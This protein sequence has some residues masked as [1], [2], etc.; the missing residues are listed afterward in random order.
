MR[1]AAL[2][3]WCALSAFAAETLPERAAALLEKRCGACHAGSMALSDL[4]LDSREALLKG[5]KRGPAIA[6]DLNAS[7]LLSVVEHRAE[8][9]MPPGGKLEASEIALLREWVLAGAAWPTKLQATKTEQWWSFQKPKRSAVPKSTWGA[10][11]IDAFLSQAHF[12]NQLNPA[13]AAD[14]ATLARRAY[15]D[16]WGIAPSAA[17]LSKFV[18]DPAPDSWPK[19]VDELLASPRYGERW[20]RHWLDLVRYGDTAGFEQDPNLLYAWRYRDYV[21]EALNADKPY[22][23]FVKEQIAGDELYP[24]EPLSAQGTGFYTVGPNRDMLY[25]VE[26]VNRE[27]SLT[28]FVDTTMSV[29]QGLT[30]GCARCHDHKFDPIPQKDYYRLRSIFMP[31]EKSRV[32][33]HYDMARGYDLSEVNRHAKL[34]EFGDQ[35]EQLYAPYKEKQKGASEEKIR[36]EMTPADLKK[37]NAIELAL[38]RMFT[39]FKAGPFSPSVRDLGREAP[40]TYLPARSG[41]PPEEVTPGFLSA[42]GGMDVPQPPR[43]AEST[44]R[45]KS[46]A[47]W[48]GSKDNPLTS[49]VMVNRIWQ[50]HFG[51]GLVASSSDYGRKGSAPSHPEL[52]D[53]LAV[54][55]MENGWSMKKLH[56]LIMTTSAYQ[57]GAQPT[58]QA[59]A[60]DPQNVWLTH[61]ARRRLSPEEMRDTMI[62][63]S[64]DLNLKMFGRPVVPPVPA[65]EFFGLSQAASNMW[66][67]T[68]DEKEHRRRS[69]Y[70]FSRRTFRPSMFETFDGPDGIRSCPR[71]E[72]SNTAPQ[73]LALFNG[74][75]TMDEASRIAS[76]LASLA[77]PAAIVNQAWLAAYGRLPDAA[78]LKRALTFLETQKAELQKP[79]AAAR[80]LMRALFNS[81]EFLYVD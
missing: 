6:T 38:V 21:I 65:E 73:S 56:K 70:L 49:R 59:L 13:K 46:L 39:G 51:R 50:Y 72:S 23:R 61:F 55:F 14:R 63:A 66:I 41:K 31:M 54:E 22:D 18:K 35:L 81:N 71:R 76:K 26:D 78:E 3:Y 62:A 28:D 74:K 10:T 2:A 4:K 67:V 53:W 24:E 11:P 64:G 5:G 29:F 1:I 80:E 27:E 12:A 77:E 69:V 43:E 48:I 34:R 57:L 17:E 60:K 75:F 45:R 8:P 7:R 40:R 47:E 33:L 58:P 42:L 36:A 52:L 16:L 68:G 20:G 25:K 79:E 15:F 32:F 44:Y 37:L 9:N 19:L 30:V